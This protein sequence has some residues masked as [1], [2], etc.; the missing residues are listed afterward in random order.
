MKGA[1]DTRTLELPGFAAA[2]TYRQLSDNY[3]ERERVARKVRRWRERL[4]KMARIERQAIM[5]ALQSIADDDDAPAA[6]PPPAAGAAEETPGAVRWRATQ[7]AKERHRAPWCND[8]HYVFLNQ[9]H[10]GEEDHIFAW[11]KDDTWI[12]VR[13]MRCQDCGY[14]WTVQLP[15]HSPYRASAQ[16][17]RR[18]TEFQQKA[19]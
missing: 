12:G 9:G 11:R 3:R 8:S 18:L 1:D 7:E 5:A 19:G 6:E 2:P 17:S 10:K 15:L 16:R 4:Q 13:T 14:E